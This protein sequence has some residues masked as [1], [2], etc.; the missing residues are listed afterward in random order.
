MELVKEVRTLQDIFHNNPVF[1]VKFELEE[2]PTSEEQSPT[3]KNEQI[4]E[5]V[6]VV[7]ADDNTHFDA[8][9]AY[10]ADAGSNTD[11][12]PVYSPELGLAVEK[13]RDGLSLDE[14]WQVTA[15]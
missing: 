5:D 2:R 15:T 7:S 14:L 9:S 6:K 4:V 8:L 11:R 1:G 10:Y 12:E 3:P 13:L